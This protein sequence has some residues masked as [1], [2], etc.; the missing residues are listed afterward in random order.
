[1]VRV[2]LGVCIFRV[3]GVHGTCQT[4][5]RICS[6][7]LGFL[8]IALPLSKTCLECDKPAAVGAWSVIRRHC[9]HVDDTCHTTFIDFGVLG[10]VG[11][12]SHTHMLVCNLKIACSDE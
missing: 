6:T 5:L 8:A 9:R 10:S 11:C 1:M 12:S 3:M 2:D 7:A 4:S